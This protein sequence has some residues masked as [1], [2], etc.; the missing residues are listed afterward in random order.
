V[1][2]I[3]LI[4]ITSVDAD[5]EIVSVAAVSSVG[6]ITKTLQVFVTGS[7]AKPLGQD[8]RHFY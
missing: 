1:S 3:E 7:Y 5:V 8:K 6:I 2:K 4:R